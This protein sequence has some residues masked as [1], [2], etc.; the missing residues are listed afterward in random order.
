LL[1]KLDICNFALGNIRAMLSPMGATCPYF[2]SVLVKY[3][4]TP[5]SA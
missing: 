4:A 1:N 5:T 2:T 3:S